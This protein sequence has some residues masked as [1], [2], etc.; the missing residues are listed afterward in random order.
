[1]NPFTP[2]TAPFMGLPRHFSIAD[3]QSSRQLEPKLVLENIVADTTSPGVSL[4]ARGVILVP[5][6]EDE[7]AT[8]DVALISVTA[9]GDVVIK[10]WTGVKYSS[11]LHAGNY[12]RVD[13]Q[14]LPIKVAVTNISSG[15]VSVSAEVLY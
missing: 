6:F 3:V 9:E 13:L 2:K 1:M 4:G 7:T 12:E 10:S 15:A 8:C 11:K 5:T 14:G